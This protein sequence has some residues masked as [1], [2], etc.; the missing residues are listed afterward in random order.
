M[1]V[2]GL[3]VSDTWQVPPAEI[4]DPHEFAA[5]PKGAVTLI[6]VTVRTEV[7]GFVIESVLAGDVVPT[8]T[9]PKVIQ[10]GENFGLDGRPVAY[11]RP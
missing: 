11:A 1:S 2:V 7:F 3:K 6:D 9:L 8:S 4:D 5:N 10:V